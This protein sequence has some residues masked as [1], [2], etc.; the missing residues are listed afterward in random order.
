MVGLKINNNKKQTKKNKKINRGQPMFMYCLVS[1]VNLVW[2]D[3]G[4]ELIIF[5][6]QS[7][8]IGKPLGYS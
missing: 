4:S 7:G 3:S 2:E 5:T 6:V 1:G 8:L